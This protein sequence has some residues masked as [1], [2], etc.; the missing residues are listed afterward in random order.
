MN[1]AAFQVD[2]DADYDRELADNLFE[3]DGHEPAVDLL[4]RA[5]SAARPLIFDRNRSIQT[6]LALFWTCAR[7][8]REFAAL[9]V[10]ENEFHRLANETG[11]TA[12]MGRQA[13]EDLQHVI[14]WARRGL[15]PFPKGPLHEL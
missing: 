10:Y 9:D 8:A 6:R 11:L 14:S 1:A 4:A 12:A 15:N 13:R 2:H 3:P 7:A 5:I